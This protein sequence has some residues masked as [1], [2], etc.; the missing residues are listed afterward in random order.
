M[1]ICYCE[2]SDFP[3]LWINNRESM[4][5][6]IAFRLNYD[7]EGEQTDREYI[8]NKALMLIQNIVLNMGGNK[9][10]KYAYFTNLFPPIFNTIF[11]ININAVLYISSSIKSISEN[12]WIFRNRFDGG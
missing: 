3:R 8:Y 2:I 7:S 4:A 11:C 12:P 6:D 5:E 9:L 1:M 10:V